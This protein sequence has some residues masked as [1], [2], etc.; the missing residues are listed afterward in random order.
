MRKKKRWER[1]TTLVDQVP[2]DN[3][4]EI[5]KLKYLLNIII[6]AEPPRKKNV[7]R[8]YGKYG[9]VVWRCLSD[10]W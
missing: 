9:H 8:Q 6:K 10:V 1:C 5:Y 3:N 7:I 2:D 4:K